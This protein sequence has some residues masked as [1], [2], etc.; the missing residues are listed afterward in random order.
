MSVI[1][2]WSTGS[3]GNPYPD[4]SDR[5]NPNTKGLSYDID[6]SIIGPGI[7]AYIEED[8]VLAS[9]DNRP[10]KN[11]VENDVILDKNISDVASE[12]D[13]G[14]FKNRY[15]EFSLDILNEDYYPDPEI[16]SSEILTTPLR[17]NSGSSIING[18]VTR[19][20]N[21]KILYFLRE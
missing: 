20:G 18:K 7:E 14:I 11:L 3:I 16:P 5:G 1:K 15:N 12:V 8:E 6:D 13:H 17:I 9:S 4:H 10:L 19:I 2:K 21:Q